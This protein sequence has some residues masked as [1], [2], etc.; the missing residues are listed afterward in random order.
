VATSGQPPESFREI[1]LP[2]WSNPI[3]KGVVQRVRREEDT[4]FVDITIDGLGNGLKE[5]IVQQLRGAALALS[6]AKHARIQPLDHGDTDAKRPEAE[7]VIAVA[8]AKG[9]VG[10][11]TVSVALAGSEKTVQAVVEDPTEVVGT[12]REDVGGLLGGVDTTQ[13][14]T[15]GVML[16]LTRG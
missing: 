2:D 10:K 15:T 1:E 9:G 4:V 3:S 16:E 13:G 5:R 7:H 12:L 6:E 14:G 8:S 11:T